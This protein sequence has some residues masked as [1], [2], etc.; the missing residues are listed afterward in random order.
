MLQDSGPRTVAATAELAELIDSLQYRTDQ[1]PCLQS[2]RT[3]R[4][5]MS[6]ELAA[7]RRWP[8]LARQVAESAVGGALAAPVADHVADPEDAPV[9]VGSLNHYS[10][11][12]VAF[13]LADAE[14]ALL[15][16]AHISAILR[17]AAQNHH[18]RDEA[19]NLQQAL[20]SR[21]VIGQAKGILMERHKLTAAQAYEVLNRASQKMNRKLR[22][23]AEELT[24]TGQI[25]P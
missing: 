19:V 13:G 15:L 8:Q 24:R 14:T 1:G 3:G 21:D 7:D 20:L 11:T 16:A 6:G 18:V 23:I 17:I 10:R 2:I 4:V 9:F 22:D 25:G 12:G 5:V